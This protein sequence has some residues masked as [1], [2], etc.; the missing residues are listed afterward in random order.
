MD[1]PALAARVR[2]HPGL[3]SK[4]ALAPVASAFGGDG[5]DA[6]VLGTGEGHLVLAAEAVWPPFVASHP[7]AAGIAGVVTVL[8]DLAATGAR[9]LALLDTVVCAAP[10]TAREVL[11]GLRAGAALYGVPVVGGHS[12]IEA[13]REPGLSTFALGRAHVPLRAANAR[14]GDPVSLV[15]CLEGELVAGVGRASFFSHLRGPRRARAAADLALLAEAG[16]AG[17]AWAARD[18]SMPG[19]VGS[20]VQLC[21]AAGGLGCAVDVTGIRPPRGLTLERW[22]VTFPSYGF[23]VVGDPDAL[24]RRAGAAGLAATVLGTLDG[25]GVVRLRGADGEEPVWDLGA[26]PLTGLGP[27][28]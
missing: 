28:R 16:E 4:R 14:A 19:I 6:A 9:A 1:L 15:A 27:P 22:L 3:V 26:E 12:T 11:D 5:D 17:E 24:A 7:R 13:V 10:E 2:T 23:L 20:L 21:E 18:V 25:S 8:N